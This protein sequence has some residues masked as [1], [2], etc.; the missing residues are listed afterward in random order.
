MNPLRK[1]GILGKVPQADIDDAFNNNFTILRLI[2]AML[3]LLG[4][5]KLLQGIAIPP[6]IFSF[7]DFA[8]D[9]FFVVSGYLVA[10]SF[11][12]KPHFG[13]FY[14]RRF[15]RIYPLYF[16]VVVVQAIGM[17]AYY[18][19]ID[20]HVGGTASYLGWNL[21]FL[22]FMEYDID[23]LMVNSGL[24]NPGINPSL[25]TLKIEVGFYAILPFLWLAFLRF[26]LIVP[27]IVFL[28]STVYTYYFLSIESYTLA[29][30]LPAQLRFFTVGM[31]LY[32]FRKSLNFEMVPAI[33]LSGVLLA[34]CIYRNE[35]PIMALYPIFIGSLVF[36]VATQIE[37]IPLT[38]DISYGVY[39]LHA[40]LIQ[41]G[42]LLG[43]MDLSL[44][45]L[46]G[47]IILTCILAYG[48]ERF[49]E[50]P[51]MRW[52]RTLSKSFAATKFS[53][54]L[55]TILMKPWGREKV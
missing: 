22:N 15:F 21:I 23:G 12:R 2:L 16:V 44:S 3:V 14:I 52:G 48:A 38:F 55:E 47:L 1:Y 36:L 51:G 49:I 31:V 6:H 54:S 13:S 37:A 50:L 26:G 43:I 11:D 8:V 10:G 24:I 25:W 46:I 9:A 40:P 32:H 35:L 41:F 42:L 27:L 5:F 39:L 20:G 19:G 17:L 18:G 34:L 53:V 45:S 28:L 33:I 29:K 4:H 7:A 30:Q